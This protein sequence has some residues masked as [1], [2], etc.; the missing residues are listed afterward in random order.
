MNISDWINVVLCILSFILAVVSVVTV[1]I[2]LRQNHKMIKNSTRPYVVAM[3]KVTNFQEPTFYLVIK[4]FGN[5]GAI[6]ENFECNIDL[7]KVSYREDLSPFKN[8][9]GSFIAPGQSYT[10]CLYSKKFKKNNIREFSVKLKYR[11]EMDSYEEV[12][13][14]NYKAYIENVNVR[15]ATE[16]KELRTISYTLQDLVEK[17]F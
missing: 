13:P 12:Y 6:I 15:A 1:V 14:I 8:I 11:D 9:A 16:G 4:N 3:A 10:C 17:L 7:N 2:T 5:S